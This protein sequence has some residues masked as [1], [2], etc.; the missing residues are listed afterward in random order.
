MNIVLSDSGEPNELK[1]TFIQSE[2]GYEHFIE[3]TKLIQ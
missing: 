1:C 2:I 3:N